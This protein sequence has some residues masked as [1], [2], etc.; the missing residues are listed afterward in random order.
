MS[1]VLRLPTYRIIT[2]ANTLL[3]M[4][5]YIH[6]NPVWRGLVL[7]AAD[8]KWSSAGWYEGRE[9]NDLK[10]DAIDA[11]LLAGDLSVPRLKS[12]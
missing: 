5:D 11:N 12:R 6:Q 2:E 4:M 7:R 8:W 3:S 10:P 9:R 1:G